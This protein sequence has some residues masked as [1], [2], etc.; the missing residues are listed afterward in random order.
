RSTRAGV[1]IIETRLL[2]PEREDEALSDLVGAVDAVMVD[3]PCS[4]SGTWRRNPELRWRLNER[5]LA[6]Y[7]AL[8]ARLLDS[9]A[10]LV[11]PGG[12][13][14]FVTCS[15]LDA[16]G[17]GQVQAFLERHPGWIA[18]IPDLPCGEVRKQGLRLSPWR[19]DTDG[20]F[21]ARLVH[22]C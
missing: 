14:V 18:E 3:A 22:M 16:E 6:G 4:G 2:D 17:A 5:L 15:L 10:R 21:I 9:A 8:Q 19:S 13:L 12:R 11:R 7:V 1:S 20:F